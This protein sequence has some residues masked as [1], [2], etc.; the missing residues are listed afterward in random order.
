MLQSA[1]ELVLLS[2]HLEEQ[3]QLGADDVA[4]LSIT[5]AADQKAY[6]K[7]VEAI[8]RYEVKERASGRMNEGLLRDILA[9][10]VETNRLL[11]N[12]IVGPPFRT[13]RISAALTIP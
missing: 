11:R 7:R 12:A 10:V 9:A 3:I 4:D 6:T 1:D 2:D 8:V 5:L 13:L